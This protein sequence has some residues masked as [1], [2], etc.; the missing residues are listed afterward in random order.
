MSIMVM[1]S[2]IKLHRR[3]VERLGLSIEEFKGLFYSTLVLGF[4]FLLNYYDFSQIFTFSKEIF[5]AFA[6]MALIV[7]FAFVPHEL[8][9]K[10]T[11]MHYDCV[12]HYEIWW[13][14]LKFALGLGII[15]KILLHDPIIFAAPGAVMIYTGYMDLYG[16]VHKK[17]NKKM[18]AFISLAGPLMNVAIAMLMIPLFNKFFI[19]GMDVAKSVAT[20]N[21]FLALFNLFPIPPLDGSKIFSWNKTSWFVLFALVFLFYSFI[22]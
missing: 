6:V 11:A 5:I 13:G 16:T 2:S 1:K 21:A 19:V 22:G 8:S 3:L 7:G 10:F 17:T 4:L 14:G 18:D 9:H 15:T 20:I 12:A